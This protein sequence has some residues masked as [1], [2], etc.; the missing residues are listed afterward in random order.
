MLDAMGYDTGMAL[1]RLLQVAR[2]MPTIV[3]HD[4]PGQVAKAGPS[5]T[6]HPAPAYVAERR[7]KFLEINA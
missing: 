2:E 3:G 1:T 7:E 5:L 6:L 4:V